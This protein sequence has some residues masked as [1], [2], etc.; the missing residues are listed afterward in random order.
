MDFP[1]W[2]NKALHMIP[3]FMV[4]TVELRKMWK[5][6]LTPEAAIQKARNDGLIIKRGSAAAPVQVVTGAVLADMNKVESAA[7]GRPRFVGVKRKPLWELAYI[8]AKIKA[9]VFSICVEAETHRLEPDALEF[10]RATKKKMA[11]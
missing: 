2:H 9:A 5:A 10:V 6:K 7:R 11:E 1:T 4:Y 8:E 3:G